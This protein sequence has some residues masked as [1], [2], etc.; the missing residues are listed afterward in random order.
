MGPEIGRVLAACCR[1]PTG[2]GTEVAVRENAAAGN[3][4]R[5]QVQMVRQVA[6]HANGHAHVNRRARRAG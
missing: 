5:A 4:V 1:R 6:N 3:D 2:T